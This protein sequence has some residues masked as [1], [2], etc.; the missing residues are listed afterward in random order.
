MCLDSWNLIQIILA[1]ESLF[2]VFLPCSFPLKFSY[3]DNVG[4]PIQIMMKM[5]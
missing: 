2:F 5:A 3:D 1:K 4:L